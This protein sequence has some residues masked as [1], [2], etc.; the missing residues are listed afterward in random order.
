MALPVLRFAVV[1]EYD[2]LVRERTADEHVVSL[3]PKRP[4][5]GASRITLTMPRAWLTS[6]EQ[7]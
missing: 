2:V 3:P 7:P 1:D 5:G 4:I 6:D